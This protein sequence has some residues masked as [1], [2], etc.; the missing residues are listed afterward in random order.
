MFNT[1]EGRAQMPKNLANIGLIGENPLR[2]NQKTKEEGTQISK[3][4]SFLEVRIDGTQET[5]PNLPS[6][7]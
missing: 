7:N 5:E 4:K 3:N 2:F 1:L 6:I